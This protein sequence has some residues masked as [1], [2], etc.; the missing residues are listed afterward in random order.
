MLG[1]RWP[2]VTKAGHALRKQELISY[3]FGQITAK[4]RKGLEPQAGAAYG[5]SEA[6]YRGLIGVKRRKSDAAFS[7]IA[8][9]RL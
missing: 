9:R 8:G 3:A 7:P 1:A 5:V 4:D 2:G 6:E